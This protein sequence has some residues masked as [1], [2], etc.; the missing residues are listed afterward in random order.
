MEEALSYHQGASQGAAHLDEGTRLLSKDGG[1]GQPEE[2]K[3]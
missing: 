1:G 3:P 2:G